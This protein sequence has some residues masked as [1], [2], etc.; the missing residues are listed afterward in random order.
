MTTRKAYWFW[1][2]LV[3]VLALALAAWAVSLSQQRLDEVERVATANRLLVQTIEREGVQRRD[4]L[5]QLFE[6]D[7]L[8]DVKRLK[9]TYQY[10]EAVSRRKRR[11]ALNAE[12]TRGL[13]D[14]EREAAAD[15]APDFCDAPDVGLPEPDPVVPERPQSLR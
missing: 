11:G 10:L 12:I 5:C 6:T 1:R 9:R 7:H 14:L 13:P 2:D 4:Q 8:A 15:S 3:P